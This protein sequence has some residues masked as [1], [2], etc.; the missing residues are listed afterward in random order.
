MAKIAVLTDSSA[1]M[2][3]ELVEQN[4]IHVIP[5]TI[6]W[7]SDM[8]LD[9]VDMTPDEFLERLANDPIHPSTTQPNPEDFTALFEKLAVDYDAIVVPVISDEL[10]GTLNSAETAAAAFD[11]V[12]V[13][14]IDT[15]QASMGL[16][17]AALAAARAA[18]QGKSLDEVESAAR[19]VASNT[20]IF[21]VVDTLEYLHRGGRIGG[22]SRLFGSALNIKPLL[23]LHEGR[24][25]ALEKVRTKK[26]AVDR[27]LEL[28]AQYANGRPV[29]A[30]VI[31]AG[32]HGEAVEL[33]RKVA[34]QFD[35]HELHLASISPAISVHTGPGTV[36]LTI[37]PD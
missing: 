19:G 8:L 2:P 30:S 23:H 25:D 26:K 17:F 10:S 12:P 24:V 31:Q 36:G 22:A 18:D 33:M 37:Y 4:G 15:R 27:M 9:G 11:S 34:K 7:G 13:R 16:G 14:V 1:Y 32:A 28:A 29:W 35:C 5:L 3:P 20:R 6:I 21:F